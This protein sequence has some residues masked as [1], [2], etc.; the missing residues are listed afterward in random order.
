MIFI[1]N[2]N[3]EQFHIVTCLDLVNLYVHVYIIHIYVI[4]VTNIYCIHDRFY[5]NKCMQ[6]IQMYN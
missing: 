1:R 2:Y 3:I 4:Y 6:F 5:K